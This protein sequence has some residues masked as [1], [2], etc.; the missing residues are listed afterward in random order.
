MTL[1]EMYND[2]HSQGMRPS[3]RWENNAMHC[4][5]VN[6]AGEVLAEITYTRTASDPIANARYSVVLAGLMSSC[7]ELLGKSKFENKLKV[8]SRVL[9][10]LGQAQALINESRQALETEKPTEA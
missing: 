1:A 7:M 9:N 8:H 2:L 6:D 10:T 5:V 4:A 3:L